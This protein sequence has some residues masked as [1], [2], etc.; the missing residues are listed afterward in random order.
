MVKGNSLEVEFQVGQLSFLARRRDS[1]RLQR[2]VIGK[3]VTRMSEEKLQEWKQP[4]KILD[5]CAYSPISG[6][7]MT[8][9]V[10]ISPS[11]SL[12]VFLVDM[13]RINMVEGK[14]VMHRLR[15]VNFCSPRSIRQH[16]L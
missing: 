2:T 9:S 13:N 15:N 4:M 14:L 6:S 5:P 1:Q 3:L 10:N 8:H 7:R 16:L 12:C 11:F